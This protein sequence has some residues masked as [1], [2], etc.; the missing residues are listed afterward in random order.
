M[1]QQDTPMPPADAG[2]VDQ[3][4]RPLVE[5]ARVCARHCIEGAWAP[6]ILQNEQGVRLN[7][8]RL[9]DDMADALELLQADHARMNALDEKGRRWTFWMGKTEGAWVQSMPVQSYEKL[10]D[11]IDWFYKLKA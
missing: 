10:R 5:A 9:L 2:P 1:S 6:N 11:Q 3:R 4:V 7:A 8:A